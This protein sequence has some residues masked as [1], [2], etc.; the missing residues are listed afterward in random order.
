MR[1]TL[2]LRLIPIIFADLIIISW[3]P[4]SFTPS[5]PRGVT[6][7]GTVGTSTLLMFG[8]VFRGTP[9]FLTTFVLSL[10]E[11]LDSDLEGGAPPPIYLVR[12]PCLVS[13][14]VF[15]EEEE[16]VGLLRWRLG[17]DI[18]GPEPMRSPVVPIRLGTGLNLWWSICESWLKVM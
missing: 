16:V 2:I 9:L 6:L 1:L 17:R 5:P 15:P 14:E 4:S 12:P 10:D 13:L 11:F 18:E 8:L 3:F 7:L